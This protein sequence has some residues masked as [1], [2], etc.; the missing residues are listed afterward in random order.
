[1]MFVIPE[2]F[3]LAESSGVAASCFLYVLM[4]TVCFFKGAVNISSILTV[5]LEFMKVD[6]CF[7]FF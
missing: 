1:M 4:L 5:N 3:Y 7:F 2:C 6:C